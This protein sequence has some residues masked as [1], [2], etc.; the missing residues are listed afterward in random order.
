MKKINLH[1]AAEALLLLFTFVL[2]TTACEQRLLEDDYTDTAL[3]PVCI[4]WTK[5]GIAD[6]EIHRASIWLFPEQGGRPLEYRMEGNLGYREI[7]VPAGVYSVLVFNETTD[8]EDW[9]SITFT[10]ADRY[11]TFAVLGVDEPV[12]GL[13]THSESLPLIKNPELLAAWS[14]DRFEVT[15]DKI[16][17]TREIVRKY[18]SSHKQA[19]ISA[20]PELTTV[21][22]LP[23]FERMAITAY[24]QNLSGVVQA[25]GTID[26]LPGGVFLV[27]GEKIARPA[28]HAFLLSERVYDPV[29]SDHGTATCTF[30]VF[31]RLSAEKTK[32]R[33]V[34]DFLLTD[35]SLHSKKMLL[36]DNSI[37]TRPESHVKTHLVNVGYHPDDTIR[38]PSVGEKADITVDNW[39]E[40]IIPLK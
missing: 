31:G 35:G 11:E 36:P 30:T 10:G 28:A 34:A 16:V 1:T 15:P 17:R 24:I 6:G 2:L 39:D 9:N 7:Q 14:L 23:R 8:K 27:S 26:G 32:Y 38:L 4:D 3:L 19:L 5:S 20:A 25:T 37:T 18:G 12:R 33:F 40:I 29:N 13:Y 21:T 22:P